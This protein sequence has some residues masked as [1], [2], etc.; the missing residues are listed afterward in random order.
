MNAANPRPKLKPSPKSTRPCTR[1]G[2]GH[3][4]NQHHNG[5]GQCAA[6]KVYEC[7]HCPRYQR[8]ETR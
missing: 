6:D 2:C 8:K 1:L 3:A 4:K 5:L 7:C